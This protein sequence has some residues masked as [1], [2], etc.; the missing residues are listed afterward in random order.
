MK[1]DLLGGLHAGANTIRVGV[2]VPKRIA[3]GAYRLLLD[4]SGDSGSA[5]A[6]VRVLVE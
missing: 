2:P 4:A 6:Y 5:H 3:K 1:R